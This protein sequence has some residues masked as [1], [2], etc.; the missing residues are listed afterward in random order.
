MNL[1][2]QEA[3]AR[4]D[5]LLKEFTT[6]ANVGAIQIPFPGVLTRQIPFLR[7]RKKRR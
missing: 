3:L 2:T 5:K 6:S 7:K 4:L 1:T